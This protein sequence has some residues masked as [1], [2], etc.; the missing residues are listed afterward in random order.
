MGL[1]GPDQRRNLR[2]EGPEAR[3]GIGNRLA[4]YAGGEGGREPVGQS[5]AERHRGGALAGTEHEIRPALRDWRDKTGDLLRRML[6]V[7]VERDNHR[8]P[9]PP[10]PP[11]PPLPR[12][13][14]GHA[15]AESG[16]LATVRVVT[17]HARP[18]GGCD[19]PGAIA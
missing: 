5:T 16:T 6:P 7:R 18:R 11:P 17:D 1:R 14:Q 8:S 19:G 13:H 12:G 9:P 15:A 3:L 10:P 4:A 2:G